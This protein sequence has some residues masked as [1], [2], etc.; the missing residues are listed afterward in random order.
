MTAHDVETLLQLIFK[1]FEHSTFPV[2]RAVCSLAATLLVFTQQ[3]ATVDP[4]KPN[5]RHATTGATHAPETEAGMP[6][7]TLMS[8]DDMLAQVATAYNRQN[9][10]RELRIG[11]IETYATL[12]ILLGTEC[13]EQ[14]YPTIAKHILHALLTNEATASEGAFAR[15][16]VMFLLHNTIGRRLLSEQGQAAA[17]R[18]LIADQIKRWPPLKAGQAPPSKQILMCATH[19]VSALIRELGGGAHAV[20]VRIPWAPSSEEEWYIDQSV[21]RTWWWIPC[22][23]C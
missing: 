19:L 6:T 5:V 9:A 13:V 20:Q 23:T 22:L 18:F 1:A 12:F 10:S 2:R 15:A 3:P 7:L 14:S 16:Q 11:L 8:L 21:C 4:N 17:I